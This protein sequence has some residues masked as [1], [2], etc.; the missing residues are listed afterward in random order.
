MSDFGALSYN[1]GGIN[2]G[3][4]QLHTVAKNITSELEDMERQ[5]QQFM[6]DNFGGAGAEAFHQVQANW[7]QQSNEMSAALAQ[8]GVR[9]MDAGEA[10][11]GADVLAAKIIG[12]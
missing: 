6:T 7:S 10:M 5:F 3:G 9:T 2:D 4:S 8:L 12:G 11:Q 1:F